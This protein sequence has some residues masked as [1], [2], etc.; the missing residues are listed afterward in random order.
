MTLLE[1]KHTCSNYIHQMLE[2]DYLFK[3]KHFI[4]KETKFNRLNRHLLLFHVLGDTKH[5]LSYTLT[6]YSHLIKP[7]CS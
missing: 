5:Y 3:N 1:M 6:F 2:I 7:I 4:F